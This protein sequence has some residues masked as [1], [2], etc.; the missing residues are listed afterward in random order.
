M[1][2]DDL[3]QHRPMSR[4]EEHA[5]AT[6]FRATGDPRL[7]ERLVNANLRL[8][9]KIARE[10]G[11]VRASVPDLV[12]E[13]NLGLLRAVQ[14][15]D[16]S[17]GVKLS[18]YASSWIRAY[19]LQYLITNYRLVRMGTTGVERKLFFN[20]RRQR[21][22]LERQGEEV[23]PRQLA[24]VLDVSEEEVVAMQRRLDAGEVSLD[25][26]V[27]RNDAPDLTREARSEPEWRPDVAVENLEFSAVLHDR[28]RHFG[29]RL[30]G[31]DAEI[32][33]ERLVKDEPAHLKHF[34]V[35][36]GVSRERVR[37]LEDRIKQQL[38]TYLVDQLGESVAV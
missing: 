28:I 12:Q 14:K 8:V 11:G 1:Y 30:A 20:L 31:R 16:P 32:F 4:E 22:K 21:E 6:R 34:A 38:R 26:P 5:V 35:R 10:Y 7:A 19:I 23:Q 37:Q 2:M 9:V 33:H 17:R 25:A 18:T 24:A 27:R 3:R 13:G 15:Y 29:S 36:F